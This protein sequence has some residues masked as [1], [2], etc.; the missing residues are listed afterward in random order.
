MI[1]HLNI[2]LNK[3][4]FIRKVEKQFLFEKSYLLEFFSHASINGANI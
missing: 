2:Y 1:Y 4:F 3:K